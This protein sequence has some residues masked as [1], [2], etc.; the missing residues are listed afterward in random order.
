MLDALIDRPSQVIIDSGQ[1]IFNTAGV[2][3]ADKA[4]TACLI[5]QAEKRSRNREAALHWAQ[6]G[7]GLKAGLTSCQDV[8]DHPDPQ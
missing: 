3:T 5:A 4:F 7:L 1:I 2:S 8:V 6:L